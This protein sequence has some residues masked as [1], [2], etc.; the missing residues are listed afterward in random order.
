MDFFYN[1]IPFN[2]VWYHYLTGEWRIQPPGWYRLY[3]TIE[4]KLYRLLPSDPHCAECGMPMAGVGGMI[5]RFYGSAP[6]SF[7]SIFCSS[8]EK[9]AR[10]KEG[11]AEVEL[12]MLFADVRDSTRLAE[13]TPTAEFKSLIQRFYKETSG[14]LVHHNSMVNRLMGDQ[15]S[16]LFVP[17]LAGRDH[18]RVAIEAAKAILEA[19]GHGRGGEPWIPVGVGVHTGIA[20]VGA[21]GSPSGVNE[22]AV[23]GSAAN[24]CARLSSAAATGEVLVSEES[25]EFAGVQAE[26]LE[27]RELELK[28]ISEIIPV[29][30]I[31]V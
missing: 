8:C 23:L 14:V 26:S 3:N 4:Q 24:L 5:L 15:V 1:K 22:I 6:S 2:E 17:R 19:T 16:A 11:G 18:A 10:K 7:S 28:G 9:F 25:V 31:K 21:V 20:F 13:R 30:V 27:R 12:S 29:R